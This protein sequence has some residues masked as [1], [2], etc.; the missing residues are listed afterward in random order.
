MRKMVFISHNNAYNVIEWEMR[1]M[2]YAIYR[3]FELLIFNS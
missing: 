3:E 1:Q 2:I